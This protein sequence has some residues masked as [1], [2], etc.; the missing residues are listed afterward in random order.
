MYLD[1]WLLSCFVPGVC[2]SPIKFIYKQQIKD[3][4]DLRCY[5]YIWNL[6]SLTYLKRENRAKHFLNIRPECKT[7]CRPSFPQMETDTSSSAQT[8][9]PLVSSSSSL[10]FTCSE[11]PR[12]P[13]FCFSWLNPLKKK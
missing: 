8:G 3:R 12:R 11:A 2:Y 13:S 5:V 1:S 6:L 7:T 10:S 9:L 4:V